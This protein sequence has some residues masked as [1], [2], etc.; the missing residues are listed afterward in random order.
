M[1]KS[2]LYILL[3]EDFDCINFQQYHIR[4]TLVDY[5]V[6]WA[7]IECTMYIGLPKTAHKPH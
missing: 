5:T 7:E 3:C 4:I 2:Y 1:G 6:V